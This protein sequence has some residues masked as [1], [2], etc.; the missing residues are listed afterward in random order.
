MTRERPRLGGSFQRKANQ[1]P[2]GNFQGFY[3]GKAGGA[4][5]ILR[6]NPSS[7]FSRN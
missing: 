6:T 4:V 2:R 3:C 5:D 1:S 7:A